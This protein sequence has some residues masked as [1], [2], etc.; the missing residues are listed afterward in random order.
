MAN[1]LKARKVGPQDLATFLDQHEAIRRLGVDR[2]LHEVG[3]L[4]GLRALRADLETEIQGQSKLL[5]ALEA[6]GQRLQAIEKAILAR[7]ENVEAGWRCLFR[8]QIPSEEAFWDHLRTLA[9]Q[10][11]SFLPTDTE[12]ARQAVLRRIL[13]LCV[14]ESGGELVSS[15]RPRGRGERSRPPP[16]GKR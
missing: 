5:T 6:R 16:G 10:Q 11:S 9:A 2:V 3:G 15:R 12:E 4:G 14:E 13:D 8:G 7:L 1:S